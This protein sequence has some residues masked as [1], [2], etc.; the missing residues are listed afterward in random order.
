MT[1]DAECTVYKCRDRLE[2]KMT[3]CHWCCVDAGSHYT[4]FGLTQ[5]D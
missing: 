5:S 2:A 1:D 3:M 4:K